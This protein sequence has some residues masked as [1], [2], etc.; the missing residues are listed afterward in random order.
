M[1][2][3]YALLIA[4]TL[5][6]PAVA[7]QDRP[8]PAAQRNAFETR[9][10]FLGLMRDYP[11][12]LLQVFQMSPSLLTNQAFLEPYPN[13]GTFLSEHPEIIQNPAFFVGSPE[14]PEAV[15]SADRSYRMFQNILAGLA[16]FVAALTFVS[17]LCWIIKMVADHRRWLRLSKVQSDVHSK[18]LDRFTSN[19]DLL[20]YI[21][22]PAGRNFLE[23]API[24]VDIGSGRVSAPASR[25]IFS[26]Q[27]GIVLALAGLGM[28]AVSVN[29]PTP[30]FAQPLFLIGILAIAI[31]LGFVLSAAAAYFLSR[32]LGLLDRA[33]QTST[34][35]TAG[36]TPPNA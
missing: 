18:L 36:V 33:T 23:S 9:E 12:F 19:Q 16:L 34:A 32:K 22:T 11:P 20:A 14:V 24:S 35:H 5:T 3:G 17:I 8:A 7:A 13:L 21:Q 31:G 1:K 30:E 4:I 26:V 6:A 27:A 25:I 28:N 15:S 10:E 2:L 29:M